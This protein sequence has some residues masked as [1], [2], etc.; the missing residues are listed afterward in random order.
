MGKITLI[1]G[2][3]RSGKSTFAESLLNKTHP[4]LYIATAVPVDE[5]MKIRI[6]HHRKDRNPSWDTL[7]AFSSLPQRLAERER[8]Y[9]GILLDCV[10]VLLT[11]LLFIRSDLNLD[12]YEEEFWMKAEMEILE[13]LKKTLDFFRGSSAEC[14]LVT[15]E[16]GQGL[17]P[18]TAFARA[19]RDLQGR[20]NQYLARESDD[21]Y[22]LVSGIPLCIKE[23]DD[24]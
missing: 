12:C 2:G 6:R 23:T 4:V 24:E 15:N 17:V 1:T 18:E 5:E 20:V 9:G 7:E 19:F 16:L 14:V 3:A 22:L 8:Y 11:N 13:D 21:V 10:T